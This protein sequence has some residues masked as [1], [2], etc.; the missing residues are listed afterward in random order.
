M[1]KFK[2]VH[3]FLE[4]DKSELQKQK[5]DIVK[6]AAER[7]RKQFAERLKA[8]RAAAGLTQ[9]QLAEKI[10]TDRAIITRYETGKAMPRSK[11]IERLAAALEVSP[12]A[13]I[14][15]YADNSNRFGLQFNKS[16][17]R[18]L[19]PHGIICE[20]VKPGLYSLSLPG[21]SAVTMTVEQC[22]DLWERC[23]SETENAFADLIEKQAVSLFIRE[24][25]AGSA[26][27]PAATTK[28]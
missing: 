27:D 2:D 23:A 20:Q 28:K 14:G 22:A 6:Q 3:I 12:L 9:A 4:F 13:L 11:A 7:Q 26:D 24:L 18:L 25:Y 5:N 21:C 19:R 1:S 16:L 17:P 15:D 10:S 8:C